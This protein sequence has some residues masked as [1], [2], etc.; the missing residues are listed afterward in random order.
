MRDD[1]EIRS[2]GTFV[3]VAIITAVVAF[4]AAIVLTLVWLARHEFPRS[5]RDTGAIT[6]L[7]LA[8]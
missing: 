2:F 7:N 3:S 5:P 8:D 4:I 6:R 1:D